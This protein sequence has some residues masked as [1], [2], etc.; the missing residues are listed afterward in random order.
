MQGDAQGEEIQVSAEETVCRLGFTANENITRCGNYPEKHD[1]ETG[2]I[3]LEEIALQELNTTGFSLQRF[4]IYTQDA[5]HTEAARRNEKKFE[6]TGRDFGY[7]VAGAHL[8]TVAGVH[9]IKDEQSQNVFKVLQTPTE[10]DPGHAEIRSAT[11]EL[12]KSDLLRF[13]PALRDVLGPLQPIEKLRAHN[14]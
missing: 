3:R 13:R 2:L 12:K 8:F 9:E 11:R 5:A 6:K 7:R 14:K 1:P 4:N 10:I